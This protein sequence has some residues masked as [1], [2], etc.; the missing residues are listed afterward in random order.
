MSLVPLHELP[1]PSFGEP[2]LGGAGDRSPWVHHLALLCAQRQCQQPSL[3]QTHTT[4]TVAQP[5]HK[6]LLRLCYKLQYKVNLVDL[7]ERRETSQVSEQPSM[8]QLLFSRIPQRA[9]ICSPTMQICWKT[10]KI[11]LNPNF[12]ST[13]ISAIINKMVENTFCLL[14]TKSYINFLSFLSLSH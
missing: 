3:H 10:T 11:K 12:T 5:H 9:D 1:W 14:H 2:C 7:S 13:T 8:K 4:V 6:F